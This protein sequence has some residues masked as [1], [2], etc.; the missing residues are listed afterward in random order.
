MMYFHL[1]IT[2]L[3]IVVCYTLYLEYKLIKMRKDLTRIAE[4]LYDLVI[5]LN[6]KGIIE[7]KEVEDDDI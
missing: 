2:S 4:T 5:V 6:H 1:V 7:I 3:V